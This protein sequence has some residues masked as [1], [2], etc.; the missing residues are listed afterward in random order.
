LKESELERS[1]DAEEEC[2]TKRPRVE[3]TPLAPEN[4]AAAKRYA[5]VFAY[6]ECL[7]KPQ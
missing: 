3:N 6:K 7:N 5:D 4:S 1:T 2:D